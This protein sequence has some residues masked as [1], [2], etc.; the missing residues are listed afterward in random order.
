MKPRG[1]SLEIGTQSANKIGQISLLK[2]KFTQP[3]ILVA[4]ES[5]GDF[6]LKQLKKLLAQIIP[7]LSGLFRIRIKGV[8]VEILDVGLRFNDHFWTQ[9]GRLPL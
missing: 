5:R 7:F 6:E 8:V 3:N 9:R 1:K 2:V 4:V